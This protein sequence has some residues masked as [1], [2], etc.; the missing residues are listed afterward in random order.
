MH[1]ILVIKIEKKAKAKI[2]NVIISHDMGFM[3]FLTSMDV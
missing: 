3:K 2:T 1:V